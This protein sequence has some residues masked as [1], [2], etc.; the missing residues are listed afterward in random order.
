[1]PDRFEEWILAAEHYAE[2]VYQ[3]T[4]EQLGFDGEDCSVIMES[5][6]YWVDQAYENYDPS[7]E[8]QESVTRIGGWG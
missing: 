6:H 5:P 3:L 2:D 4:L 8:D 7:P 1:M